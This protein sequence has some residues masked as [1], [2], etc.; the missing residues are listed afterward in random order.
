MIT[1]GALSAWTVLRSS[2]ILPKSFSTTSTARPLLAAQPCTTV[3]TAALRSLSVQT[4]ILVAGP[5]AALPTSIIAAA[6]AMPANADERVALAH[7]HVPSHV[8]VPVPVTGTENCFIVVKR[9]ANV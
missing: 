3:V 5:P 8:Q 9:R 4:V 2:R 7:V 1:S 6:V